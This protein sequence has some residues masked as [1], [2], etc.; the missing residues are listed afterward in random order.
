MIVRSWR[1]VTR[2]AD[3]AGYLEYLQARVLPELRSVP[4]SRGAYVL[5]QVSGER[6][7]FV[8]LSFWESMEAVRAFAGPE[9]E[10]AMIHPEARRF[11]AEADAEARHYEV[12]H[13]PGDAPPPA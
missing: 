10:R 6:A 8:V 11:L 3:S 13:G 4:A 5:R 12:L 9:P 7:E 2:L 1:G